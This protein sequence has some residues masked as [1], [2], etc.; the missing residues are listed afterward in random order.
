MRLICHDRCLKLKP[1]I[2]PL[3]LH[4]GVTEQSYSWAPSDNQ[5]WAVEFYHNHNVYVL[6]GGSE[7]QRFRDGHARRVHSTSTRKPASECDIALHGSQRCLLGSLACSPSQPR[8]DTRHPT[9]AALG[10][11]SLMPWAIQGSSV[12]TSQ[13]CCGDL[14]TRSG[15]PPATSQRLSGALSCVAMVNPIFDVV[16]RA[17]L[18]SKQHSVPE[19]DVAIEACCESRALLEPRGPQ[20]CT[21]AT[22]PMIKHC[23]PRT[24]PVRLNEE[25]SISQL[26]NIIGSPWR[27]AKWASLS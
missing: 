20:R 17:M 25:A 6:P 19:S 1:S 23:T 22:S 13:V 7:L 9:K 3:R 10:K 5:N 16:A 18:R 2:S 4:T 8:R 15:C 26:C 27:R 12:H 14:E 24:T 21:N 11:P